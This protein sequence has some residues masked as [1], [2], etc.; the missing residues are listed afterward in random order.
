[1]RKKIIVFSFLVS[2]SV[3]LAFANFVYPNPFLEKAI[4][5]FAAL[6]IIYLI[7]EILLEESVLKKIKVSTTRYSLKKTL[8]ILSLASTAVAL[9]VIWIAETQYIL[10]SLGLIGAAIAFALQD[11]FKNFAGGVMIFLNGIYHVGDRI[12]FNQKFG[13]VIDV[14]ILYT[15]LLETREWVSG[16]QVTGRLTIVPNGG[17]LT[18]TVQNYTRDFDFIW[19]ELTIPITYDSDWREA[20]TVIL[21]IVKTETREIVEKAERIMNG[22]EGKYYF[23]KRSIEPSIF[24][25]LTDNWISFGIRYVAEVRT[26]RVLH[27]HISRRILIEMEKSDKIRIASS[28]IDIT[29]FPSIHLTKDKNG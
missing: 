5:T 29:G 7:F 18:G 19:D 16:D 12:E 1:M 2:L 4:Y 26:R 27:D 20:N 25:T 22:L 23:Q 8:S 21:E 3:L 14:G 11:I 17:V 24:L 6:G 28:T 15:T 13:D 10:L 9:L